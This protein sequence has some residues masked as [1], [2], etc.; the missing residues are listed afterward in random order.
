MQNLFCFLN[1]NKPSGC[2]SHDVIAILRKSIGIKK[3]GHS[4]TLD[5]FATGV[6]AVG[7]GDATRLF[8]YLPSDK[9]YVAEVTFGIGTDTDDI[10]GKIIMKSE[11]IPSIEEIKDKLKRFSGKINQRPPA[12]SAVNINGRRAYDLARENK[13]SASELKEREVEIYSIEIGDHCGDKLQLSIHCSAGTYIR[14]I[15]RDL[16]QA[17]NTS[18]TLS[19]LKRIKVGNKF[20]IEKSLD[21]KIID[22]NTVLN[23]LILPE[24]VIELESVTL[25]SVEEEH[26]VH[27][28]EVKV[29]FVTSKNKNLQI[30]NKSGKLIGIGFLTESGI[31]K[32]K[33]VFLNVKGFSNV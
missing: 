14:S 16:G 30:L 12:Y 7:V 31:L 28:R 13:I 27:G 2:T 9:T 10:T 8:E 11:N 26:I 20:V 3:I 22:K 21:L 4:G 23:H 18:A 15:A 1:I 5:P 19:K 33:K 29:P 6:L 25:N 17:L 24:S 32:P